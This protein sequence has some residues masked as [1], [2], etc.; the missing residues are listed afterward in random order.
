MGSSLQKIPIHDDRTSESFVVD[1]EH[2][3]HH[4]LE[5]DLSQNS[6]HSKLQRSLSR[7]GTMRISEKKSNPKGSNENGMETSSRGASHDQYPTTQEKL[8]EVTVG[9]TDNCAPQI[10]H[11]QITITAGGGG[12]A[13]PAAQ[14]LLTGVRR[15]SFRRP[16]SSPHPW[17]AAVIDPRRIL[18][19]FA[20][21]SSIGTMLLIYFTLSLN[22]EPIEDQTSV[23]N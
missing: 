6:K 19:A 3:P 12:G 9:A 1:M 4:L 18:F 13:S 16:P 23:L 11:N 10:H 20:T 17:T 15:L 7:K 2:F 5:K 14:S 8:R 21:L 22:L